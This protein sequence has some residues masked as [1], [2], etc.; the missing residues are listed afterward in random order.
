MSFILCAYLKNWLNIEW[1]FG[2]RQYWL[3]NWLSI[4]SQL[5]YRCRTHTRTFDQQNY[6][7]WLFS[8]CFAV[9]VLSVISFI[10]SKDLCQSQ[11]QRNCFSVSNTQHSIHMGIIT[12]PQKLIRSQKKK[13]WYSHNPNILSRSDLSFLE[14][15]FSKNKCDNFG[16]GC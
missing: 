10:G 11:R 15:Q 4:A 8:L 7:S 6:K 1:F 5:I 2:N 12:V 13:N 14:I 3:P 16:V 9:S